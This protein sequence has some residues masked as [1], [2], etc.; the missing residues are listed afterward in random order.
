MLC[1]KCTP[2]LPEFLEVRVRRILG[3]LDAKGRITPRAAC[4]GDMIASLRLFG[5]REEGA[6][7][8]VRAGDQRRVDTVIGDDGETVAFEG[9]AKRRGEIPWPGGGAGQRHRRHMVSICRDGG[10]DGLVLC[11]RWD[12]HT[13]ELQSLMRTSYDVFCLKKKN[14][15]N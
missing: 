12:E 7:G 8:G 3:G 13:F 11:R 2:D 9:F 14:K 5:Q 10:H 4:A 15:D 1:L 6:R